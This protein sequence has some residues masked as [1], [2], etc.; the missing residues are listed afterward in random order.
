V[1]TPSISAA[2]LGQQLNEQFGAASAE[3]LLAYRPEA[4]SETMWLAIR[5]RVLQVLIRADLK[6]G[7][8]ARKSLPALLHFTSWAHTC[9]L[10]V[11]QEDFFTPENVEAWREVAARDAQ[12][13]K[14]VLSIGSVADHVS[15]LRQMGPRVNP[16]GNWPPKA[17]KID[18]GIR[19]RLRGPYTDTEVQEWRKA[20]LTAPNSARRTAAEGF[21]GLGFGAGLAPRELVLMTSAMVCEEPDGLWVDVPGPRARRI[22][23]AAPWNALLLNAARAR[24]SESTLLSISDSKNG[25]AYAAARLKLLAHRQ[26]LSVRRMRTTWMVYRLRAGVDPR[27]VATWAGLE[28]LNDLPDLISFMPESCPDQ[29]LA[30]MRAS[31][32]KFRAS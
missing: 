23:V 30:A 5:D 20:V 31:V 14:G 6:S 28:T 8:S 15:R 29:A 9:G 13:G 4:V 24:A 19:R 25:L 12:L 10:V 17:G 1:G 26:V 7:E 2:S 16:A 11:D 27:L 18:G 3:R 22:P 32:L 21:M